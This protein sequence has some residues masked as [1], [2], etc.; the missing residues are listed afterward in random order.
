MN[1]HVARLLAAERIADLKRRRPPAAPSGAQM[2]S[3]PDSTVNELDS[4]L[5]E[6]KREDGH[7]FML[8]G[9]RRQFLDTSEQDDDKPSDVSGPSSSYD[10]RAGLA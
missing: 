2:P 10:A 1:H 7:V 8:E 4:R 3:S 6:L 5:R 9:L